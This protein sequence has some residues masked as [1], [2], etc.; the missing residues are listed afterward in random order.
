MAACSIAGVG[1]LMIDDLVKLT[2]RLGQGSY[3]IIFV[4]VALECQAFL[5]LFMP[6]ETL[7][8]ASGFLAG[9]GLFDL[10]A[11]IITVAAGAIVGDSIGYELGRRVG[12]AWLLRHGRWAGLNEEK[13]Q[14]VQ[15]FLASHGGKSVFASHFL[16]LLRS[17]MPFMAGS[18][19]MRY[20]RF[21]FYNTMGCILWAA[22]FVLVGYG[23]GE[24][25]KVAEHWIG[26]ASAITGGALALVI[27]LAWLGRWVSRH[28]AE[29]R[30]GWQALLQRPRL[31]D[32]RRRFARPIQFLAARF[33]PQ[34][35]I[36]LHLTLGFAFLVL[37]SWIF[38]EIVNNILK[39]E[40]LTKID[41]GV[42]LWLRAHATIPTDAVARMISCFG[43][44]AVIGPAILVFTL[45]LL[46][47]KEWYRLVAVALTVP[48]GLVANLL[49]K[50]AFQ[51]RQPDFVQAVQALSSF[52]IPCGHASAATLFY[53]LLAFFAAGKFKAWRWRVLAILLSVTLILLVGLARVALGVHYLS[54]VLGAYTGGLA[55]LTLCFT[56]LEKFR[57][58]RL[59]TVHGLS[60]KQTPGELD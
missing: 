37:A 60:A 20:L 11:L 30:G 19:R 43:S 4:V 47:R 26:R 10:K 3:L 53:G 2:E 44:L 27:G 39:G 56:A 8:L 9:Q 36:A 31:A 21:L 1:D 14:R 48:G 55:W 40:P 6:G 5:G 45:L 15:G 16:H 35:Y 12:T 59:V 18:S 57:R 46:W 51:H 54:D 52:S 17:L 13:L 49:F 32:F 34:E 22:T 42:S 23:L 58:D 7:V 38:G 24:S 28:E 50:S 33:T 29:I 25:W 41:R